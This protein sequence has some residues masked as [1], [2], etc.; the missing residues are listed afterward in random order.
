MASQAQ[1]KKQQGVNR[2]RKLL[3]QELIS[4]QSFK[5]HIKI[6]RTHYRQLLPKLATLNKRQKSTSMLPMP[7]VTQPFTPFLYIY[8]ASLSSQSCVLLALRTR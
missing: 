3:E 7:T 5:Q 8:T 6:T 4:L 2:D 1:L